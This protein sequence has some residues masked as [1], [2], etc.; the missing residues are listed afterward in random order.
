VGDRLKDDSRAI[1]VFRALVNL[2]PDNRR[3]Q[4]QLKKRYVALGR[5]DDLDEF[6]ASS[7]RWDE[8][9]R[10]L[11]S[12]ESRAE[13]VGQRIRMLS[14]IAELWETQRQR[15]ERAARAYEKIMSLDPSNSEAAGRLIPIYSESN[16]AK[17]LSGVLEVK[18][19][20]TE[21]RDDKLVVLRQLS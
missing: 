18:L 16:N 6:Y 7:G 21:D 3:A 10:V 15:P 19:A 17:G 14:K 8:F 2:D 11:E 5:W 13:D 1:E 20:D 4:E 12:N 9:I